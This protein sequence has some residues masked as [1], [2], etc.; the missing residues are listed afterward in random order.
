MLDV[1]YRFIST[2]TVYALREENM[3]MRRSCSFFFFSG[4]QAH[5]D[6]PKLLLV[7]RQM[8]AKEE[9]GVEIDLYLND[10]MIQSQLRLKLTSSCF[11][12]CP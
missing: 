4:L 6:F 10:N 9:M 1:F 8:V 7:T 3:G 5:S 2:C 11:G 12:L